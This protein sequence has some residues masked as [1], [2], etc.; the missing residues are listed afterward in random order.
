[1]GFLLAIMLSFAPALFFALVVYSLDRFEK[2]PK[3]LLGGVFSWGAIVATIGAIVAQLILG[4][5]TRAATGSKAAA[6]FAGSTLW[7]PLT[8]ET[9]K[10]LA[11]LLV[12]LVFRSEFDSVLDGIV[13]A[14]VAA[15]GFAATENVLYLYGA[16]SKQ[17]LG[18]LI[19]LFVLRVV[20]GAWDHPFY[21]AFTGIG[22]AWFRLSPRHVARWFAPVLGFSLAVFF[23]SF[24]NLMAS[25]APQIGALVLF[26][27][28]VDWWG[29]LFM[30]I[31]IV[32]AIQRE[33]RLLT[34][35]LAE[36]VEAGV[37]NA[38]QYRTARSLWGQTAARLGALTSG[39]LRATSRLY[40]ACGELAHKKHQ[41]ATLGDER[42]NAALVEELRGELASL[43]HKAV[44]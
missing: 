39:R 28:V 22:L 9:L 2:E 10:A 15:L 34:R 6:E 37:L 19:Q 13:Y 1:M 40:Q 16:Y 7:A 21:T 41:L 11:V 3:L 14:G 17:G 12:F 24:H 30:G 23:H 31:V 29:W 8:E 25:S 43:S 44:A 38:A 18:G 35:Y 36:E 32:W 33:S 26:M 5:A 42:G 4:G 20:M 27:F